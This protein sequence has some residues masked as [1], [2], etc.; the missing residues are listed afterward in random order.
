MRPLALAPSLALALS[1][2]LA[3]VMTAAPQGATEIAESFSKTKY[4]KKD[5][6]G[7]TMSLYVEVRAL[8]AMPIAAY[9]GRY[10]ADFGDALTLNVGADGT[11]TGNGSDRGAFTLR[12]ARV[13]DALLTATK[14]YANGETE[15]LKGAFLTRTVREG[16]A[17]GR[18]RSESSAFGL[19]VVDLD[20]ELPG[21]RHV[22][23]IFYERK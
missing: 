12:N 11:L 8:P 3:F 7:M 2:A 13:Q 23:R 5:K 22:E 18:I 16:T 21:A 6:R 14:V 17:P 20:L 1:L 4:K 19:G 10:E 15:P 9:A